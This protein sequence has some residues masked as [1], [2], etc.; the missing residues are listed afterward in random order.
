MAVVIAARR[1]DKAAAVRQV[2]A[3][4]ASAGSPIP[5]AGVFIEDKAAA[6]EL[7][8][9]QASRRLRGSELLGSA[10]ELVGVVTSWWPQLDGQLAAAEPAPAGSPHLGGPAQASGQGQGWPV[11]SG[12][13]W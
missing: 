10:R 13:Q 6:Q 5:V 12:E 1:R 7:S 3:M 9:G 2:S 11:G 8:E 4:L